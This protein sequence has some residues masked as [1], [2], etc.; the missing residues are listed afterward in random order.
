MTMN[1]ETLIRPE[2]AA[3]SVLQQDY[4]SDYT[5]VIWADYHGTLHP[6]IRRTVNP[7]LRSMTLGMSRDRPCSVGAYINRA[8]SVSRN[9]VIFM[10]AVLF[11]TG[12]SVPAI[13]LRILE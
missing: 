5:E 11:E 13:Q 6:D 3:V 1:G 12:K 7:G 2:D 10:L 4:P 8:L 9:E